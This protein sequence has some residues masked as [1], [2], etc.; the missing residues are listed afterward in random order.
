MMRREGLAF[1]VLLGLMGPAASAGLGEGAYGPP[2]AFDWTGC[3]AGGHAGGLW[4][5]SDKWIVRTEGGAF[6][7]QSLGAHD[8]DN[9]IGGVQAGC[10][11]QFAG[12]FVIGVGGEYGW[13]GARGTHPSAREFGVFYHSEV[14]GLG[15]ATG[16]IGYAWDRLLAYVEAGFAWQ[17]VDYAAST[18]ITGTAFTASDTRSGW[19]L[20]AGGEYAMTERV[21]AFVEYGHY[22]FGT[23]R[24]RFTPLL[25]GL[26]R[27]FLDIEDTANVV[28]A[29]INLRFGR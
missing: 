28:R 27:A 19:T 2:S 22:D 23:E 21:S 3:Y 6:Q 20:G 14:Q 29:G 18:I 12:G 26:S 13:T 15:S 1:S 17:R 9:V 25:P 4:G 8:V 16:R 11:Y 10:D 7:G 5:T 24:I